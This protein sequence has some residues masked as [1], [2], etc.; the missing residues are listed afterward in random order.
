MASHSIILKKTEEARL[1]QLYQT[2]CDEVSFNFLSYPI[3]E[4]YNGYDP[5]HL[6]CDR[7][8]YDL[9]QTWN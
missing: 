6:I 3:L 7:T 1:S 9:K 8:L 2:K 4:W 5:I